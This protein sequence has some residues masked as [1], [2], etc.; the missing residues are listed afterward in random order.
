MR[1]IFTNVFVFLVV[2]ILI[3]ECADL[4]YVYKNTTDM[5]GKFGWEDR[6]DFSV[7][8]E[9]GFNLSQRGM[10]HRDR[11]DYPVYD[12]NEPF[13]HF[14]YSPFFA[15]LMIPF[16]MI[17]YSREALF[18]W[19]LLLNILFLASFFLFSKELRLDFKAREGQRC[20]VMWAA[21]I[22]T[23]R[24]YLMNMRQGQTDVIVAFLFALLLVS[25]L[26]DRD[27][28]SGLIIALILQMKPSFFPVL[29]Y[30]LFIRKIRIAVYTVIIFA[31][32]QL[33]PAFLVGINEAVMLF[34]E[35]IDM[36]RMSVP[37][38]VLNFKNYSVPYAVTVQLMK[39]NVIRA[40][41]SPRALIYALSAIS[42]LAVYALTARFRR[43]VLERDEKRF[44]YLEISILIM[45]SLLFSSLTW[46]AHFTALLVPIGTAVY[47]AMNS[48]KQKVIYAALG[49]YLALSLFGTDLTTWIPVI[50]GV[51]FIN[52]SIAT[53]FLAF[54]VVLGYRDNILSTVDSPQST[55]SGRGRD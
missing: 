49:A 11:S 55:A 41:I 2:F 20:I 9:A 40:I 5:P 26:R 33:L 8:W 45:T 24:Y 48:S 29:I 22:G 54:A 18:W 1:K 25:Y 7:Y 19:Y 44:R 15:F 14:R 38:Q 12:L 16:G 46:E 43:R 34:K 50:G 6:A 47:F 53:F 27:L 42:A 23:L 36:L 32:L 52:I 13:H 28:V 4:F 51:R 3:S 17:R 31:L 30:F 39:I 10:S 37:S 35:W 21:F